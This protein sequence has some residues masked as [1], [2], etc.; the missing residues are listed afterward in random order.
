ML[1]AINILSKIASE[2]GFESKF[3][4]S[5]GGI[6][7]GAASAADKAFRG[8]FF[9]FGWMMGDRKDKIVRGVA[10]TKHVHVHSGGRDAAMQ[11]L[12]TNPFKRSFL[13]SASASRPTETLTK[14]SLI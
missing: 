12:Y 7:S 14:P 8:N 2:S 9:I 3:G 13:I 10:Y 1:F 11:L 6:G 4:N 5:Y